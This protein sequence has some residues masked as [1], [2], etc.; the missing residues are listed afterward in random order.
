[1]RL[2]EIVERLAALP[3]FAAVPRAEL[4]WLAARGEVRDYSAGTTVRETG[5]PVDEMFVLLAG[6]TALYV[7]KEGGWRKIFEAGTGFVMGIVPYSRYQ[8][9]PGNVVVEDDL[10]ALALHRTH[11][12][13]LVRECPELTTALVHQMLDRARDYRTAQLQDERMQSLGRLASGLAHELNNPAS[14]ATR[15]AQTL[16][17][18]LVDAEQA[19]RVLAA[20]RLSDIQLEAVDAVRARCADVAPARSALEA[21]DREDDIADWLARHAIDPVAAETLAAC[22]VSLAT[23][24]RLADVLPDD[25]LATAIRWIASGTAARTVARQIESATGRIHDLVG[26]VKGFTFMD[27]EGIPEE[28]D[29]AKGLADTIAMLG[30]KSSAKAVALRL[31]TA[32]DLPRVY[33]LGS[34]LNQVWEKLIDNAVDAASTEGTVTIT[35]TSRGGA[36]I[37]RVTDDGPGI[38]EEIRA[39]VFD[40]FFTTKPVGRGTGLSLDMARRLVHLHNGDVDFVSQP[41]RTVF[42]VRL[43]ATGAQRVTEGHL[44]SDATP[45]GSS[46]RSP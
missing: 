3:L 15:G 35:A 27:R 32:P 21:A 40:P 36:V 8:N 14:A 12:P 46:P 44:S 39:R 17:A 16:A 24:D 45:P 29:V 38:P 25:S 42:R 23:L 37:V 4:E 7:P 13:D 28:V 11:L 26:A 10:T 18:L 43:P 31:E 30:N 33:G 34:E 2:D 41:G 5:D 19:S 20:A 22:D 1:M 6:R 9:A